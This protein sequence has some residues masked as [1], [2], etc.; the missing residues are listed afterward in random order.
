MFT[1]KYV[2]PHGDSV[3]SSCDLFDQWYNEALNV[4]P[5]FNIYKITVC[6]SMR[7]FVDSQYFVHR[8]NAPLLMIQLNPTSLDL[9]F[10]ARYTF[11][12]SDNGQSAAT[13]TPSG[14]VKILAVSSCHLYRY[15]HQLTYFPSLL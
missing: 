6:P 9:M 11:L 3:S 4:N 1:G 15:H 2:L 7:A 13:T 8:I 10:K 5:C 12:D 14:V